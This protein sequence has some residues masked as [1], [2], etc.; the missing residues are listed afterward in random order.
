MGEAKRKKAAREA[1][2]QNLGSVDIER[3]AGAIRKLSVAASPSLG[4]DCYSYAAYG[5]WLLARLGVPSTIAVGYAAW[6][7][8]D[9]DHDVIVHDPSCVSI[10]NVGRGLAYHA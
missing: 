6:R 5:Q 3:V 9:G 4:V 7:V 8:G 10:V 2:L 1:A